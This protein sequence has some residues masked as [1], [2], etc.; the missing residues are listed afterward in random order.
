MPKLYGVEV[1]AEI[2]KKLPR[3]VRILV[4]GYDD[5]GPVVDAVNAAAVHHYF[6]KPF[7]AGDMRA[8]VEALV[9][10][11]ELELERDALLLELQQSVGKLAELNKSL[12]VK[13]SELS[14][15]VERRTKELRER[16]EELH[17]ANIRLLDLATRDGLTGLF[18]H[19]NF[20]EHLDLEIARSQRYAREFC[21]LFIDV[22]DFKLINDNCGHQA[23]DAVLCH[24]AELLSFGPRG[25]RRSDFSARYG[26]EEFCVLLPETPLHG[27]RIKA[28]RIR[29]EAQQVDW[30][31]IHAALKRQVT[32]SI[33]VAA[34]PTHG[35]STDTL[36]KHADTALYEAKRLGK[37]KVVV[38]KPT[39]VKST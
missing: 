34:F 36:L 14:S 23:G 4:T 33:G 10:A 1:L 22:D 20:L 13:E 28:E 18:N 38:H 2:R 7:H 29:E 3:T 19:K 35:D 5:Y 37:N 30:G 25:L 16:N 31:Q 12:L 32:L 15:E 6:E 24:L 26:G 9:L 21:L 8:V 17:T 27:G 39:Q 11:Q